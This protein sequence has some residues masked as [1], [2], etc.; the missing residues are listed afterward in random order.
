MHSKLRVALISNTAHRERL[1]WAFLP[2]FFVSETAPNGMLLL[3]AW[4]LLCLPTQT[5]ALVAL[6]SQCCALTYLVE[7]KS[8]YIKQTQFSSD[9]PFTFPREIVLILN[10]IS[11]Q[12]Q[13]YFH[14]VDKYLSNTEVE[15][16]ETESVTESS[17]NWSKCFAQPQPLHCFFRMTTSLLF[18][19]AS[20]C[21]DSPSETPA[22]PSKTISAWMQRAAESWSANK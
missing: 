14:P 19:N 20:D 21:F 17:G 10:C 1:W 15:E 3:N 6:N 4:S 22:Q 7:W 11:P 2:C 9:S 12:E 16:E 8:S 18:C 13:Y 5:P